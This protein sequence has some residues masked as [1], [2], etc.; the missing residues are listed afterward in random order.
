MKARRELPILKTKDASDLCRSCGACCVYYFADGNYAPS[1]GDSEDELE[2]LLDLAYYSSRHEEMILKRKKVAGRWQCKALKGEFD[3]GAVSCS[4]YKI[5]PD[6]CREF[7]P[8]SEKCLEARAAVGLQT[9][10]VVLLSPK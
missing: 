10:E 7:E 8:L 5:R 2:F 6:A 3:S 9:P 4:I 1:A